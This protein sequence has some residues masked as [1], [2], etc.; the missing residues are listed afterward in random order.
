VYGA[1][2]LFA[3]WRMGREGTLKPIFTLR[4]GDLAI[5]AAT[6]AAL[7]AGS[8]FVRSYLTPPGSEQQAWLAYISLLLGD[9]MA[10]QRSLLLTGALLTLAAFEEV[11]WRAL[12]LDD[13]MQRFGARR[14]WPLSAVLYA[15]SLAPSVYTLRAGPAGLNP[16][17]PLAALGCG[18]MWG[19]MGRLFGRLPPLVFSHM[20]FSYFTVTGLRLPGM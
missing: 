2:T 4:R 14:A 1:W 6:A 19:F 16:L 5:G 11:V 10:V 13:L 8:Y 3:L 15:L 18:L 17:L 7:L 20:V 12:V 9:P